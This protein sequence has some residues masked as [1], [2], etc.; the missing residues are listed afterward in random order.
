[1]IVVQRDRKMVMF[2]VIKTGGKQYKVKAGDVIT[3]DRLRA[4]EGDVVALDDVLLFS[5]GSQTKIG[6]PRLA[7]ISVAGRVIEQSRGPKLIAFKK[8]RRK[9]SRRKRGHRQELSVVQIMEILTDGKKPD[10][11]AAK[12]VKSLSK[13][14]KS[15]PAPSHGEEDMAKAKKKSAKRKT[16]TKARKTTRIKAKKR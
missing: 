14:A 1:M 6:V 7:D 10:L 13:T 4:E 8:R 9:N 15:S 2:A 5:D 11:N 3:I 16:A 12:P